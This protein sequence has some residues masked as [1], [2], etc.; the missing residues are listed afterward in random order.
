MYPRICRMYIDIYIYIYI[1]RI[2]RRIYIVGTS[3]QIVQSRVK[4]L[5]KNPHS[6]EE[7]RCQEY[8]ELDNIE[9]EGERM[10]NKSRIE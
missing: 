10:E 7:E 8:I 2:Y 4:W 5:Q 3:L 6:T 1:Y 9:E